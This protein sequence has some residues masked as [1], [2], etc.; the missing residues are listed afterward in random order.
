[1]HPHHRSVTAVLIV[2]A[3]L[4]PSTAGAQEFLSPDVRDSALGLAEAS[5]A[6]VAPTGVAGPAAATTD[7]FDW[8]DAGIGAAGLLAL[9]VLAAC[10][11]MAG[12]H[13]WH[14]RPGHGHSHGATPA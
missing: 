12:A 14:G 3:A 9:L 8:G 2:V 13:W 4:V 1:M 6:P 11:G 10:A 5:A 7:G